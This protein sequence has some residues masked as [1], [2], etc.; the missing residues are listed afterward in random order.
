MFSN[1]AYSAY[2]L[3]EKI[4]PRIFVITFSGYSQTT[5]VC[6]SP[7][8]QLNQQYKNVE[9]EFIESQVRII[10]DVSYSSRHALAWK[11]VNEVTGRNDGKRMGKINGSIEERKEKW[12]NHFQSLLG[13]PPTIPDDTFSSYSHCTAS[14]FINT[15]LETAINGMT[16]GGAVG[17]DAT[18]L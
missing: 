13:R 11:V 6:Y 18:P 2:I 16:R 7:T 10:E 14:P 3:A 5:I 8:N 15:E 17:T 4:S 12:L 9:A 1:K